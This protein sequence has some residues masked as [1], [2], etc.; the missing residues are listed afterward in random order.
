MNGRRRRRAAAATTGPNHLVAE[1]DHAF[2]GPVEADQHA[3]Q[4]RLAAAGLADDAERLALAQIE[5]N[6][7]HC[8]DARLAPTEEAPLAAEAP[9]QSIDPE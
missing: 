1:A 5:V 8:M 6:L 2:T 9:R 3:G 7:A 4:G